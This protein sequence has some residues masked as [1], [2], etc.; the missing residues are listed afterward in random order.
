[1]GAAETPVKAP[2]KTHEPKKSMRSRIDPKS[3]S[4]DGID[5]AARL[6]NKEP[7]RWYVWAN[8]Q[9]VASN[10]QGDVSFYLNMS[11]S[12]GLD[13]ADGYRTEQVSKDGVFAYGALSKNHGDDITNTYGQTLVS[14]PMEFKELVDAVGANLQSGQEE[15]DRLEKLL[16]SRRNLDDHMRG[17]GRPG[18]FRV[19][20]DP[21]HG[22]TH[23]LT[24]MERG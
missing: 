12:M 19:E 2:P 14:C 22:E 10:T 11:R 16:I 21:S 9:P 13:E 6:A 5:N 23:V 4:Q 17:V 24:R 8:T 18:W 15:A 3:R 1:M 20:A 7:G